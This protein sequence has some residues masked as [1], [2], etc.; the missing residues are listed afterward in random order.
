EGT[1]GVGKRDIDK[2]RR[3]LLTRASLGGTEADA[4]AQAAA[5]LG[6]KG[7]RGLQELMHKTAPGLRRRIASAL[8]ASGTAGA[9]L[10]AVDSLLD[11]DPGLVESVGR[12]LVGELHALAKSQRKAVRDRTFEL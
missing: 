7:I 3:K 1:R 10:F 6:N 11:T 5:R 12:T 8:A 2:A 4:A 9:E